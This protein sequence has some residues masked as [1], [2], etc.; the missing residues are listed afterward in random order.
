MWTLTNREMRVLETYWEENVGFSTRMLMEQVGFQVWQQVRG[1]AG[2]SVPRLLVLAGSGNN[3]GD[4]LVAARHARCAGWQVLVLEVAPGSVTIDN[5]RYNRKLAEYCQ[6][7]FD[8]LN[9]ANLQQALNTA[10]IV[11]EGLIG[12]GLQGALRSSM[13]GWVECIN[14]HERRH[15]FAVV[16][17]DIPAGV[18]SDT[19][20]VDGVALQADRTVAACM[21]K[22]GHYFYPGKERCGELAVAS[23]GLPLS[24]WGSIP[25][26][27]LQA[28]TIVWPKRPA[29]AHKG[30]NGHVL[31]IAGSVGMAGA[32][33]LC[34]QAALRAG[35]GKVTLQVPEEVRAEIGV[36]LPE[37]MVQ[38]GCKGSHW[39]AESEKVWDFSPYTAVVL[40][41]GLGRHEDT[42]AWV[43]EFLPQIPLPTV[44]D[45]DALYAL[46][47]EVF[48]R[49][50]HGLVVT[51]H[52]GE[53]ARLLQQEIP[54]AEIVRRTALVNYAKEWG[55]VVVGKGAPTVIAEP[56]GRTY[57]NTTGNAGLATAGTGDTLA[58]MIGAL[59][60]Q[61]FLLIEAA[62]TAV[63]WHGAAGDR[64]AR[65]LGN[66]FLASE[67]ADRLPIVCK[68]LCHE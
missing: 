44:V 22:R 7:E 16:A 28:D 12:T 15:E 23:M 48:K 61:E 24:I 58:G 43:R 65:E 8:E 30:T 1:M 21:Y 25:A 41:C 68:E 6:V 60:A 35:A 66:G 62:T 31:V 37:I 63:Y 32:A 56:R 2:S 45:A 47:E 17:I 27:I 59:L 13:A 57:I 19:G 52:G 42:Q 3:G 46:D 38:T 55:A 33:V 51:P 9:D 50:L 54:Q 49:C 4:A 39:Q 18:Q 5:Y 26:E 36:A 64:A 20:C 53:L 34:A 11:V 40:G 14:R 67:V 10:D 29:W